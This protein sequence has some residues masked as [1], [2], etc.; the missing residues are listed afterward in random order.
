MI[1]L[2][3]MGGNREIERQEIRQYVDEHPGKW[4]V[5]HSM[6]DGVFSN[7]EVT[8]RHIP[9]QPYMLAGCRDYNIKRV[10]RWFDRGDRFIDMVGCY[11]RIDQVR[12]GITA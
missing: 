2:F 5:E 3:F 8:L 11:E 12:R 4:R 7:G 6:D 9:S 1:T 10:H